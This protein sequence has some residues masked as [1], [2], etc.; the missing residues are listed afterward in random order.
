MRGS[1]RLKEQTQTRTCGSFDKQHVGEEIPWRS[2]NILCISSS[3]WVLPTLTYKTSNFAFL[4][5]WYS[6]NNSVCWRV[7]PAINTLE[8][9]HKHVKSILVPIVALSVRGSTS[10][11][12]MVG[13]GPTAYWCLHLLSSVDTMQKKNLL[14]A[15]HL[16]Q[17]CCPMRIV[18][19]F[20]CLCVLFLFCCLSVMPLLT[21]PWFTLGHHY[22]RWYWTLS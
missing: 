7:L 19:L 9:K 14:C 2:T 16:I 10:Q 22:W 18:L 15:K 4:Q 11:K 6:F 1:K 8:I 3:L 13:L 21:P 17:N 12:R 5:I 20:L